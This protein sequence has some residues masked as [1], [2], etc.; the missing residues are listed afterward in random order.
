MRANESKRGFLCRG[1]HDQT[2]VAN[3]PVTLAVSTYPTVFPD[4]SPSYSL[5][6]TVERL[7]PL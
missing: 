5:F 2:P 6:I 1:Q 7:S 3:T 4:G